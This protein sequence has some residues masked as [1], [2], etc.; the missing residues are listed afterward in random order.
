MNKIANYL[1]LICGIIAGLILAGI[2]FVWIVICTVFN[3]LV[4]AVTGAAE[5]IRMCA[6]TIK[7]ELIP[8]SF[9]VDY[10]LSRMQGHKTKCKIAKYEELN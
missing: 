4:W 7:Y 10:A 2:Y 3:M 9:L 6:D 8:V 1:L 5:Q